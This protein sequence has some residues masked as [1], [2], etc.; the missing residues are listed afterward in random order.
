[1]SLFLFIFIYFFIQIKADEI[2]NRIKNYISK[3]NLPLVLTEKIHDNEAGSMSSTYF[4]YLKTSNQTRISIV[5]KYSSFQTTWNYIHASEFEH[6]YERHCFQPI[7]SNRNEYL[8]LK[9]D[10][11]RILTEGWIPSEIYVGFKGYFCSNLM[12]TLSIVSPMYSY[13]SFF[14]S[15]EQ[16][17]R[18]RTYFLVFQRLI[19]GISLKTYVESHA[20]RLTLETTK[21]LIYSILIAIEKLKRLFI[22]HLDLNLGNLF[23]MTNDQQHPIRF[24]D[25][26]VMKFIHSSEQ[27]HIFYSEIL[28]NSLRTIFLNCPSCQTH[29]TLIFSQN[30]RKNFEIYS[31]E[32]IL[33]HSW[34]F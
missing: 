12:P 11:N 9:Q 26:G 34:F 7:K 23:L 6:L 20:N 22:I 18:S 25:F 17:D 5:I 13:F 31:I 15:I 3:N 16:D 2:A 10:K 8:V 30:Y 14:H 24:I 1:M 19:N 28:H 29:S 32:S 21:Y 33:N 4:G 27:T